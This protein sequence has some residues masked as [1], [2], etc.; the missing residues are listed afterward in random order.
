MHRCAFNFSN[1]D[2]LMSEPR[3]SAN[4]YIRLLLV[5][6]I[7]AAAVSVILRHINSVGNVLLVI[8]GF[9]SV[10]LVHELAILSLLNLPI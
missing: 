2:H 9:G 8:V 5:L 3:G 10:V 1:G 7:F 6:I 4:R